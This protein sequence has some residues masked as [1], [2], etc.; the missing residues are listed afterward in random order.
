MRDDGRVAADK[1]R[2]TQTVRDM[3][4]SLAVIVLAAGVAYLFIP[5]DEDKDPVR[6]VSYDIEVDQ[7][8][9]AA[10]YPV[11]AP[12][13][14]GDKWRATSVKYESATAKHSSWHLGFMTPGNEYAAVEQ[15]DSRTDRYV[16]D[17]TQ[18]AEKTSRTTR[19]AGAE[20]TRYEGTKYDALVRTG[21]EATTVVTGTAS[22]E[23][24]TELAASLRAD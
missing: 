18:G 15:S 8:R 1:K 24:L 21:P 4:L 6:T 3:V 20:W 7:A 11:A 9:R 23:R 14:L 22:F 19:I 16:Q 2:G 10:P 17:V 12:Q 5:N 13:G